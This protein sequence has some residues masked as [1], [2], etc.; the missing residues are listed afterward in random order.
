MAQN[1]VKQ[2]IA[3]SRALSDKMGKAGNRVVKGLRQAANGSHRTSDEPPGKVR[4]INGR[5]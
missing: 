2:K 4:S 5:D 3:I 1:T